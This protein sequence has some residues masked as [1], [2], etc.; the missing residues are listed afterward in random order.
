MLPRFTQAPCGQREPEFMA[1]AALVRAYDC[2]SYVELG[3]GHVDYMSQM[4]ILSVIGVDINNDDHHANHN[5]VHYIR[6]DS[7]DRHTLDR[8]LHLLGDL[9]DAVFIDAD[10]ND[11]SPRLDFELWYPAA[12]KLV[13]FHDILIPNIGERIWPPIALEHPSAKIVACDRASAL[14][15][16]GLG[17]PQ[18]GILSAGGIGII[19][20]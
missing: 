3:T 5:G 6:G 20:K 7:H 17:A 4:G 1:W 19:Y 13:G 16:Q 11:E 9:P 18:N 2:K 10:H 14:A 8:V 12:Q 15:W